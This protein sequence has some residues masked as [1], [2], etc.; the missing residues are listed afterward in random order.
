MGAIK[1]A[2]CIGCRA[3]YFQQVGAKGEAGGHFGKGVLVCPKP[4]RVQCAHHSEDLLTRLDAA[5]D[6]EL[7]AI[8]SARV[9]QRVAEQTWEAFRLTALEGLSGAEAAQQIP[10]QVAQVFVAK[11]RVQ[12]MLREEMAKLDQST[13]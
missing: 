8:A 2:N 13:E 12:K 6:Q 1:T 7:V 5:F 4:C 10:M 9:R 3:L 11:R